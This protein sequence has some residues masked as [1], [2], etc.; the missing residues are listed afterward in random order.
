MEQEAASKIELI[1]GDA[2]SILMRSGATPEML[3]PFAVKFP[4]KVAQRL[5]KPE[6][7]LQT[8]QAV[9]ASIEQAISSEFSKLM[10]AGQ[11]LRSKIQ[12][13]S[14]K[15]KFKVGTPD[16]PTTVTLPKVL[17][18]E[19]AKQMGSKRLGNELIRQ[20]D[21]QRPANTRNRS[22]WLTEELTKT[23]AAQSPKT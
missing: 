2:L 18:E 20:L 8:A 22:S 16:A 4:A 3:G 23:L 17:V 11:Q 19:A 5:A 21:N 1:V 13:N 9:T 10:S 12:S 15:T 14:I 6:Q 7:E